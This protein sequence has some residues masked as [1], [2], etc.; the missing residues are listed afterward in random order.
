MKRYEASHIR[1]FFRTPVVGRLL[2]FLLFVTFPVASL[3]V[4]VVE[5]RGEIWSE[6]REL[7]RATFLPWKRSRK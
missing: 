3:L 7:A 6:W 5:N 2:L 4:L 1:P